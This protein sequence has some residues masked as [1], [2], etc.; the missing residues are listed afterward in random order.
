MAEFTKDL[1]TGNAL[2]DQEHRELIAAI[3]RL[4]DACRS[5]KGRAELANTAQFMQ[6]YTV[7]HFSDE[8]RLQ[9][10]SRFPEY[11]KHRGY[12][13]AFK[14]VMAQLIKKLDEQGPSIALVGELN[15]ALTGWLINHIKIEDKKLAAYLREK[16]K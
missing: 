1:E 4:L 10:Q 7:K 8:E 12:H 5:G 15:T 14:T 9:S 2:I 3:N 13:E 16:N 11:V 6:S